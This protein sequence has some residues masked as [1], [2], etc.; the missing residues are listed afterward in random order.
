MSNFEEAIRVLW[1]FFFFVLLKGR[2]HEYQVI[3]RARP[4][5]A[6]PTPKIYRMKVFAPTPVHAKSRFWYF[7]S[8]QHKIKRSAGEILAVNEVAISSLKL[9]LY[10]RKNMI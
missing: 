4:T 6:N 2:L 5:E 9:V 10:L 7:T 8:N 3:G 1:L